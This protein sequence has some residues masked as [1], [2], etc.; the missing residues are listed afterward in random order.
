MVVVT[1]TFFLEKT[2]DFHL[3]FSASVTVTQ[4]TLSSLGSEWPFLISTVSRDGLTSL[5]PLSGQTLRRLPVIDLT[6]YLPQDRYGEVSTLDTFS[7]L[8]RIRLQ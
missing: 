1:P 5:A 8:E 7:E 3:L 6:N 2:V 4:H